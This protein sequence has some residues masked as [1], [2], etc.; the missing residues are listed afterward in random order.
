MDVST[1]A[2]RVAMS[3]WSCAGGKEQMLFDG[4]RDRGD[5]DRFLRAVDGLRRQEPPSS[6][7]QVAMSRL[8]GEF[9]RM[10]SARAPEALADLLSITSSG[11]RRKSDDTGDDDDCFSDVS[12]YS[13]Q[14]SIREKDLI[15]GDGLRRLNLAGD[16][17]SVPSRAARPRARGAGWPPLHPPQLV[18]SEAGDDEDSSVS[19]SY[20]GSQR[21]ICEADLF[22][23]ADAISDLHAIASRMA[24]A[25]Y[26]SEC[27]QAYTSVRKAAVE[28]ALRRL[29]VEKLSL[30][31]V[32]QLEWGVL[33]A[34]IR[35]WIRAACAAIR[36]VFA[37]ERRLCFLIFH[38]FPLSNSNTAADVPFAEVVKGEA[39]QLLAFAEAV[40]IGSRSRSPEKLFKIIDMHD[41][42]ADLLPDISVIFAASRATESIYMQAVKARSSLAEAVRGMLSEFESAVLRDPSKVLVPGGTVHPLTRYVMNYV[43]LILDYKASL[44]ELITS[45]PSSCSQITTIDQGVTPA[46]PDLD[47]PDPDSQLPFAIH[48]AWI[49]VA[50]EYNLQSKASLYKDDALYHFFLM[51]NVHYIVHK[52]RDSS[53]FSGL[54]GDKYLKRLT[55]E[56]RQAAIRYQRS[57]W[58][59]ILNYLK[60][61]GLRVGSD[62]STEIFK[63][64]LRERFKGFSTGFG[65]AHKIQSRWYV[66]DT[67]MREELRISISERLLLAYR[68]FLGKYRHHIEKGKR[69]NFYIKYSVEDLEVAMTDFFE[70]ASPLKHKSLFERVFRIQIPRI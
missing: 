38:E 65:E 21:S 46:F 66:P 27:V 8:E 40:S 19:S 11:D 13:S 64:V 5:A 22:F 59:E 12:S 3:S 63:L 57:G 28:L 69:P 7:V 24:A 52:I 33:K 56:F 31:D 16:D 51:N 29:G 62:F 36:G 60:H 34:K 37:S 23:P 2:E 67:R 35:R 70:G 55:C 9:R 17:A 6:G 1:A 58:L 18:S 44:S 32:Q 43:N 39:Q 25:G 26:G 14:R 42:I 4:G 50:L 54:I 20:V 41:T 15:P 45:G 30:D 49:I 61:E 47:V 48:L 53:Q 10:L 68:P